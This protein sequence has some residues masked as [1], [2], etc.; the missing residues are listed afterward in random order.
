[1]PTI[2]LST[3]DYD[4]LTLDQLLSL[5]L[6][7]MSILDIHHT[8]PKGEWMLSFRYMQMEMN[9]LRNGTTDL[10][11][12]DVLGNYMITPRNMT[13]DMYMIGLMYG[14]R[15]DLTVMV[16][17]SYKTMS[18]DH[19][20]RMGGTFTTESEGM[21]DTK[22]TALFSIYKKKVHRFVL[23]AGVSLP[24]GSIDVRD[25]TPMG[26]DTKLPY[27][28]RLGSGTYDGIAGVTY[29]GLKKDWSWGAKLGGVLRFS[30]NS[31]DY[32]LGDQIGLVG[33]VSRRWNKWITTTIRTD[34]NHSGD[35]E[36]ADPALN[37]RMVPTADPDL[38]ASDIVSVGLGLNLHI[39][40]GSLQNHR[41]S[42]EYR[43]PVYQDLDGPQLK[44][45]Q[46]LSLSWSYLWD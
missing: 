8:H 16:M 43:E 39:P 7:S 45:D 35:I 9:G 5:D 22:L 23:D 17:S 4:D 34:G 25:A 21:G 12:Q 40:K 18:M 27:P 14:V 42:L 44:H 15:E 33:W 19:L 37:P 31:D 24:T 6:S 20:T 41:F 30:D 28:M 11:E 3:N 13:M 2:A 32:H 26:P 1:M 29:L 10:S 46:Q 36:G 38:R